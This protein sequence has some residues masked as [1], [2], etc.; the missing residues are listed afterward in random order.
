MST[1]VKMPHCLKS[2][3]TAQ[4]IMYNVCITVSLVGA[5]KFSTDHDNWRVKA[6]S[7][8]HQIFGLCET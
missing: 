7:L 4:F 5:V 6:L 8:Y 1:L 3:A 2:H